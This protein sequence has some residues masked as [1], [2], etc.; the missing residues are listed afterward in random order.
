MTGRVGRVAVPTGGAPVTGPLA[1]RAGVTGGRCEGAARGTG[2]VI[3]R[4]VGRVAVAGVVIAWAGQ[5]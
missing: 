4:P 3:G 2:V 1:G 5:R